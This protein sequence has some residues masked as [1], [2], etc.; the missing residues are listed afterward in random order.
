MKFTHTKESLVV[1]C[2]AYHLG[3]SVSWYID[4]DYL[5]YTLAYSTLHIARRSGYEY[6][7]VVAY[8]V[9]QVFID[10]KTGS[11]VVETMENAPNFIF[12]I[13]KVIEKESE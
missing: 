9:S 11:L 12:P 3:L 7:N 4:N 8:N 13:C 2:E 5:K 6:E 1:I 10:I